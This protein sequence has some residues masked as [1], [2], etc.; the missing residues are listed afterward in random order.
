MQ[1]TFKS[2]QK[3]V[4]GIDRVV[5]L[6]TDRV[7]Y[8]ISIELPPQYPSAWLE[9]IHETDKDCK[10]E[11]ERKWIVGGGNLMFVKIF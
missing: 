7:N 6:T 11:N 10:H 2:A 1:H 4:K 8:K 3:N 5:R 9:K